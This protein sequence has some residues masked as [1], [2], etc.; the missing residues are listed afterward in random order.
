V[1][2]SATTSKPG[3]PYNVVKIAPAPVPNYATDGFE[4]CAKYLFRNYYDREFSIGDDTRRVELGQSIKKIFTSPRGSDDVG[5][6]LWGQFERVQGE[7]DTD[8]VSVDMQNPGLVKMF[9]DRCSR[10]EG[11]GLLIKDDPAP[12]KGSNRPTIYFVIVGGKL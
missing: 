11:T 10:S 8:K 1:T 12:K 7:Y 9:K 2:S 3:A 5:V 6:S 4:A